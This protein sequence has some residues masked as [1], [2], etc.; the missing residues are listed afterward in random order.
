MTSSTETFSLRNLIRSV[1]DESELT[2]PTALA[3]EVARRVPKARIQECFV[4]ML[5]PYVHGVIVR[6]RQFNPPPV[7]EE[8]PTAGDAKPKAKA[9]RSAKVAAIREWWRDVLRERLHIGSGPEAWVFLGDAASDQ[10]RFA[11]TERR[12]L[13]ALNVQNAE[14]LEKLAALVEEHDVSSANEL[15]ADVL[16]EFFGRSW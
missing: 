13:A 7:L 10:L 1:A 15:P 12:D 14:R 2:D 11:A 8:T 3:E 6:N 9:A 5:R 4:E 16:A